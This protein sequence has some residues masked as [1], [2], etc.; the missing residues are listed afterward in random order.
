MHKPIASTSIVSFVTLFAVVGVGFAGCGSTIDSGGG[1]SAGQSTGGMNSGGAAGSGGFAGQ[2]GA[3]GDN[4]VCS[5]APIGR[6][7]VRGAIDAATNQ[8]VLSADGPVQFQ[9]FPKGCFSSSCTKIHEASCTA[10][11]ATDNVVQVNGTFCLEDVA[12]PACTADCNGGGFADCAVSTL[13]AGTYTA[14]LGALQITFDVP[15][16]LPLGGVCVGQQF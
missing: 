10:M 15:S 11:E 5:N 14:T 8:E 1:G 2:G 3:G 4:G 7:C 6:F 9:V 12:A 13:A 16:N